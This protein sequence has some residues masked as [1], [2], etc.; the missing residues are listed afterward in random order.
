M[1]TWLYLVYH[2]LSGTQEKKNKK[3]RLVFLP[4][5]P[6]P[7]TP[8]LRGVAMFIGLWPSKTAQ[9]SEPSRSEHTAASRRTSG[10]SGAWASLILLSFRLVDWAV[11]RFRQHVVRTLREKKKGKL[12]FSGAGTNIIQHQSKSSG[13]QEKTLDPSVPLFFFSK[14]V[15]PP[16]STNVSQLD[17]RRRSLTDPPAGSSSQKY[18]DFFFVISSSGWVGS[19]YFGYR[20]QASRWWNPASFFHLDPHGWQHKINLR[21]SFTPT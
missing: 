15:R 7:N 8:G 2:P 21:M 17:G 19:F 6:P 14:A 5:P 3:W 13:T 10:K 4:H 9:D 12:F 20:E 18:S 16:A 11:Y 1:V